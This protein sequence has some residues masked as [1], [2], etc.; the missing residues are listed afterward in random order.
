MQRIEAPVAVSVSELKDNPAAILDDADGE[1]V[2]VLD[3]NRVMA[4]LVPAEAYEAMVEHIDD[5]ELIRTAQER[6]DE[7]AI[8]VAFDDL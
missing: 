5:I 8:P 2:A 4:Y 7:T 3:D 6:A 1:S